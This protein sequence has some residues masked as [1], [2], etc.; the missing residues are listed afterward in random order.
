[1]LY[2]VVDTE[3]NQV[4]VSYDIAVKANRKAFELNTKYKTA[5]YQVK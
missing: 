5:R 4:I 2:H 3:T 1:M